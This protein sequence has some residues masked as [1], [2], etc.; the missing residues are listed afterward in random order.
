[1]L[2]FMI[3]L[4]LFI[5][6]FFLLIFKLFVRE[7]FFIHQLLNIFIYPNGVEPGAHI[8][9]SIFDL[10]D[11]KIAAVFDA[12]YPLDV[13]D[14]ISELVT[15]REDCMF[16]RD[17]GIDVKSYASIVEA[18]SLFKTYNRYI[19]DYLTNY[20]IYNPIN[21]KRITV[22]AMYDF[23]QFMVSHF[24]NGAFRP[25]AGIA[26]NAILNSAIPGTINFTPRI[27]PQINQK[28]LLEDLRIN[29]AIFQSDVC[30]VQSLYTSQEAYTQLSYINNVLAIQEV[31]RA[32]RTTCPK[33]RWT[34]ASGNDFSSYAAAVSQ[35]LSNYVSNFAELSFDYQQNAV[36]ASQKIFYAVLKFRFN[37]WA[38][39]EIFDLYALPTEV[40]Q[41]A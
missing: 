37:N 25:T 41:N 26:N 40:T 17:L 18:E 9:D 5:N 12:N 16:F 27:T 8:E 11:Y 29:Y 7:K 33:L 32:V 34:F 31:A 15:F 21:G 6:L 35:V 28:A 4:C 20:Q 14:Q 19:A 22:T 13:K 24:L 1:M 23:C 3:I 36:Y 39:T 10:D 30:V 38:Q 2:I